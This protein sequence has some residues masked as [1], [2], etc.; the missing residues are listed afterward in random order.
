MPGINGC[1]F[2]PDGT[3]VECCN[4]HDVDFD[5]PGD[6]VDFVHSN[7]QLGECVTNQSNMAVATT[8]VIGVMVGGF[9]VY[10][11][12]FLGGKSLFHWITGKKY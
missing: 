12:K 3:W 2:F 10:P 8:M 9:F 1:D 4:V 11:F 6:L 7:L 5:T